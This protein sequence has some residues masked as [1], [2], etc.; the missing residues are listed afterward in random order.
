[1]K[2]CI[3]IY[4][5]VQNVRISPEK[6][7]FLNLW[8]NQEGNILINKAYAYWRQ[9]TELFEKAI[10]KAGFKTISVS[11]MKKNAVDKEI[12][13][14]CEYDIISDRKIRKVILITGDK[15][16]L[17]LVKN[18]QESDISVTLISRSNVNKKLIDAVKQSYNIE[19][20]I[21]KLSQENLIKSSLDH[22]VMITYEEAKN[23]LIE[24]IK[25]L[26]AEKKRAT[27]ALLG[28]LIKNHPRLS[29]YKKIS[30]IGKPDGKIFAKFSKFVEAVIKE[31]IIQ[32]CN[33]E[34]IL[35]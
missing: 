24:L 3:A 18:L 16:Y 10:F 8:L 21:D 33:G 32:N 23:C 30:S 6:I 4:W 25:T 19:E 13:R 35:V 1:M 31:G 28:H 22:S 12:I 11:S 7:K 2:P 15:D 9:E 34:L 14:D 17:S 27:I 26:K 5:D 29:G 20:L